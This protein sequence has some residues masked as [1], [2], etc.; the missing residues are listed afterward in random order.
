MRRVF[1]GWWIVFAGCVSMAIS[2]GLF[3]NGFGF[4]FEPI[5]N[6]FAWNRTV[7]SGAYSISRIESALVGPLIGYL[8][9]RF[10]AKGVVFFSFLIFGIGFVLIGKSVSVFTFY[11]AFIITATGAEPPAFIAVMASLNNWFQVNRAKAIGIAMLGLGLGGIIFPPILAYGLNNFTWREVSIASGI[12]IIIVGSAISVLVRLNPEPYGYLPD[13]R[14]LESARKVSKKNLPTRVTEE[15]RKEDLSDYGFSLTDALKTQAFWFISI[16]HAQALLV[17]SVTGLY[18]VPYLEDSLGFSRDSAAKIVMLLTAVNM[19]GQ[20]SGGAL[21]D[22]FS[23]NIIASGT[24]LGH[25]IGLWILAVAYNYPLIILYAVIQ[26]FSWGVRSP[27]ITSMRGDYFGRKS[28]PLIMGTS[29]GIAMIGMVVGP[30]LVGYIADH[31]SYSIGFRI[32]SLMTMPGVILF[33]C[34]KQPR[35]NR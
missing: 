35:K 13:G 8:I 24:I 2:S 21:A 25:C 9:Q 22:R 5:R 31:Y 26:G 17:V 33:L 29:Q 10:G 16:G 14:T 19:F 3:F 12:F 11:L 4:F 30:V 27:V 23:K 32:I 6:H 20:L 7:L 28:F 18:Q 15:D 34:I 1:Y